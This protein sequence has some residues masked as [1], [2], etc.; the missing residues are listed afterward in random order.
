MSEPTGSIDGGTGDAGSSGDWE[1]LLRETEARLGRRIER[2]EGREA[3]LRWGLRITSV[4]LVV[5][6]GAL[7]AMHLASREQTESGWTVKR[8][9]T[10]EVVLVD[11]DGVER[12]RLGMND[13]GRAGIALADRDGR[14][15][16]RL[17]VLTD[18]SPGIT[19]SDPDGRPR[20]VLGYLPDGTTN[21]V[22]ADASGVSRAVLG[23][24]PDGSTQA[25]FADPTGRIRAMVGV[26][27]DGG[28]T[29][30]VVEDE[31]GD[32]PESTSED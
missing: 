3:R 13:D 27:S 21:L 18:G 16:I 5:A 6:L 22:F 1:Y 26:G 32:E 19:I 30:S 15:R 25:L 2:L 31:E 28:P 29:V 12:G 4:G 17:S 11:S 24:D 20:A 14:D 7:A 10:Q 8:L 9:S 23:L